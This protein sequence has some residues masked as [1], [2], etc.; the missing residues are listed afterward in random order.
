MI[1]IKA[2]VLSISM[3]IKQFICIEI[4]PFMYVVSQ[5]I[6]LPAKMLQLNFSGKGNP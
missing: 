3:L 4:V 2:D 1:W 5:E 6:I